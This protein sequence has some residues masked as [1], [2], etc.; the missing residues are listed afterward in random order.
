MSDLHQC[1]KCQPPCF[2]VSDDDDIPT[3]C[4]YFKKYPGDNKTDLAEWSR[5]NMSKCPYRSNYACR[6]PGKAAANYRFETIS[7][8][9]LCLIGQQVDATELQ[10]SAIKKL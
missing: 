1:N 2:L 8:C 10:T 3:H 4:P 6:M 5:I 9:H 7:N